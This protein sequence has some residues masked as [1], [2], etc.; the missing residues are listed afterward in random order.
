MKPS[1]TIFTKGSAW[2][3]GIGTLAAVLLLTVLVGGIAAALSLAHHS[4]TGS[5]P[6]PTSVATALPLEPAPTPGIYIISSKTFYAAQ[7]SKLDPQT[8]Q[9]LWTQP[10]GAMGAPY[11]SGDDPYTTASMPAVVVYGDT[12]YVVSGNSNPYLIS[13]YVYAFDATTGAPRWNVKVNSDSF[14]SPQNGGPYNIGGLS[15]PTIAHGILYV[16]ARSGKLYAL[17]A[18][19]GAQLWTYDAHATGFLNGYLEDA[20]QVVVDQN[21]VYE[22]VHNVLYAVNAST[23]KQ[24]WRKQVANDQFLKGPVIANGALYLTAA[25]EPQGAT[26]EPPAGMAYAYAAEDGRELWRHSVSNWILASPTV[27]NNVVYVGAYDGNLYAL[28]V[29]DGHEL[30][31]YNTGGEIY[32]QPLVED[33]VVYADE[34]GNTGGISSDSTMLFAINTASG[35]LAWKQPITN[36]LSLEQVQDGVIYAGIFP[37]QGAALSVK[38]GSVLW[39]QHYGPV[40][41]DKF[42]NEAEMPV[43]VTVVT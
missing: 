5:G 11:S 4:T 21:A 42:N 3:R 39:Q 10:V 34:L 7:L 27:V 40:L 30:W 14:T 41:Y 38:D 2:R 19:T 22:T 16:A 26:S 28:R 33:G 31:H 18:T 32:D 25:N 8:K 12:V 36:M 23:G 35:N 24:L 17:N 15:R 9:P 37:G 1:F 6:N 29:R 43:M 20:N 13:N